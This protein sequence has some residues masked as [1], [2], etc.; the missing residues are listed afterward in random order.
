MI[1]RRVIPHVL[2]QQLRN[3][4]HLALPIPQPEPLDQPLPIAPDVVVLA[5]L[6]EHVG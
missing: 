5:V 4:L 3:S 1:P 6:R 2:L